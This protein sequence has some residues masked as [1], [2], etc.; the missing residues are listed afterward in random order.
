MSTTNNVFDSISMDRFI[1]SSSFSG[2]LALY[3]FYLSFT[4][5]KAFSFESV[6]KKVDFIPNKYGLAY[7]VF[8][9]AV[10]LLIHIANKNS[11]ETIYNVTEYNTEL[12]SRIKAA[13][14]AKA[15]EADETL[16]NNQNDKQEDMWKNRI[17]ALERYFE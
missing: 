9:G 17:E 6:E 5:K 15:L 2:L 13:V 16:K 1:A 12:G 11:N 4:T 7:L 14:T 8:A 3:C 10:N